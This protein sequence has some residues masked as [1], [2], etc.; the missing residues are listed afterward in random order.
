M[1]NTKN[2]G[3]A[4][5]FAFLPSHRAVPLTPASP[6][7]GN[8]AAMF[9]PLKCVPP[10]DCVLLLRSQ[11]GRKEVPLK[12]VPPTDCVLLLRSQVGRKEVPLKCV[13]PTDCVLLLRSQVGRKEVPSQE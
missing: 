8:G 4:M 6:M 3:A 7:P 10:T 12:C 9:V 13:P 1:P 2:N 5:T 11:V